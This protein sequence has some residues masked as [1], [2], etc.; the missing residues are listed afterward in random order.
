VSPAATI[1]WDALRRAAEEARTN[2]HAPYSDYLVGA[3]LLAIDGRVFTGCNVENAS[4]PVGLCAERNAMGT[5]VTN[6]ARVFVAC[7]VVTAGDRPGMPCGMCRQALAE[8]PPSF[9][10]RAYTTDGTFRE[11][12]VDALLPDAFRL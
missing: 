5:A 6:G 8:L 2:A 12:S 3:A 11:T 10:I 7:V 4:Y 9:P 1:D